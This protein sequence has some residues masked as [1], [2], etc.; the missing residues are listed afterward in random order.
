MVSVD[1]KF[2]THQDL[3]SHIF[4]VFVDIATRY[5]SATTIGNKKPE[6]II[7]AFFDKWISLFGAPRKLLSDNGREFHNPQMRQL[8]E[9]FNF[10]LFTT[11][12]E[13]PWSNGIVE[14]LNGILGRSV[15]KIM[16]DAKCNVKVALAWAVAARNACD[17]KKGHSP[18][19]LVL[20]F[21]PAIPTVFNSK[22]PGIEEISDSEVVRKNLNALHR[23]RVQFMKD[24]NDERL[25]RALKHKTR[26]SDGSNINL[27]DEIY[28]KR[29]KEDIWRGPGSVVA[30]E[31]KFIF[32]KHGGELVK[33]HP[34][35]AM[36]VP[37][38]M[39][40]QDVNEVTSS[41]MMEQEAEEQ[42]NVHNQKRKQVE[43]SDNNIYELRSKRARVDKDTTEES[44]ASKATQIIQP[45]KDKG[46]VATTGKSSCTNT[47]RD[48]LPKSW[49][50]GMRFQGY[51]KSD[52]LYVSGEIKSRAGKPT[53]SQRDCYWV[54]L[55]QGD[56]HGDPQR[57]FDLSTLDELSVLENVGEFL[58]MYAT[59]EIREAK[60]K[61]MKAWDDNQVMERVPDEGQETISARWVITKKP[62]PPHGYKI[63]A[64]LVVR[65]F[66]EDTSNLQ[67]DS[68]TC[69]T[70]NTRIVIA[71]ATS[72]RWQL[73]TLDVKG[74]YLQGKGIKRKIYI[75]PP[76]D[77][78]QS[79]LWLLKKTVYGLCD[80]ARAWYDTVSTTLIRLGMETDHLWGQSLFFWMKDGKLQ[81]LLAVHVDDFMYAGENS[82]MEQVIDEF[83]KI[84]DIGSSSNSSFTYLGL[85]ISSSKRGVTVDQIPYT[86]SL[87]HIPKGRLRSNDDPVTAQEITQIRA[88]VGQLN[89]LATHTRPDIAFE[90]SDL[91]SNITNPSYSHIIRLNK[92]I[93][94]VLKNQLQ[95]YF[96]SL[97]D[98]GKWDIICYSDASTHVKNAYLP[99]GFKDD[100][101]QGAHIIF[102]R[103]KQG[104]CCPIDWK[105]NRMEIIGKGAWIAELQAL[106][107]A[108]ANAIYIGNI[109]RTLMGNRIGSV[110]CFTD[111]NS[112][113]EH[114][115]STHQMKNRFHRRD[116]AILRQRVEKG[117]CTIEW[118]AGTNQIADA[119][120][121]R[122]VCTEKLKA[123]ISRP[124]NWQT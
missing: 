94:T 75:K 44:F 108:T 51:N 29:Q 90:V 101:S 123:S 63:K 19:T 80:A 76:K 116:M 103:D 56:K 28:Y 6:T 35:S 82:F 119:M 102:L 111:S 112:L 84:F 32:V 97:D 121:K 89:W 78:A 104:K 66:E 99:C 10:R 79:C 120:T 83:I 55:D 117:F 5:C 114:L 22:L 38:E 8:S 54:L 98:T 2:H 109:L 27:G 71:I 70:E 115:S 92:V 106:V 49:T 96:P 33:V 34:V 13:S 30:K 107:E 68:P 87:E 47:T 21:N 57:W 16:E 122:G 12:A 41:Q 40:L 69:S 118:V 65:G 1:L 50:E 17:N 7:A 86:E 9:T 91:G 36:K 25:K 81:G 46:K 60:L 93:D 45:K 124:L 53:G 18:N 110:K 3:K 11:A 85:R 26:Q 59:D 73:R 20:S 74:A 88:K 23:A 100:R 15:S 95:M 58:I 61:E 64:R 31:S 113:V 77:L 24:E 72:K 48:E 14:R 42:A 39:G 52:G 4:I 62:N 105:S 43:V 67:T 37:R